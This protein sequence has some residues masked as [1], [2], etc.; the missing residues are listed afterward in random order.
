MTNF[1]LINIYVSVTAYRSDIKPLELTS[2]LL[3]PMDR[4]SKPLDIYA[5]YHANS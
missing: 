3:L 5:I 1:I 4:N 2:S